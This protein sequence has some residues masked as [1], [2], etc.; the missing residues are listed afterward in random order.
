M[1]TETQKPQAG[2]TLSH[3]VLRARHTWQA[4]ELLFRGYRVSRLLF[5]GRF[6]GSAATSTVSRGCIDS[7]EGWPGI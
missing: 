5:L 4:L 6:C 2:L 3:F 7:I 1:L